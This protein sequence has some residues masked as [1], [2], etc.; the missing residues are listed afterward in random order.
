MYGRIC[1]IHPYQSLEH[2]TLVLD[3][4]IIQFGTTLLY[5]LETEI[6]GDNYVNMIAVEAMAPDV[7]RPSTAIILTIHDK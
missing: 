5:E 3:V 1:Y 4:S 6:S 2:G 7:V